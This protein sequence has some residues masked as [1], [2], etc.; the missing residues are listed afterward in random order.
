MLGLS[1]W[2][3]L[4]GRGSNSVANSAELQYKIRSGYGW[5][6]VY[7]FRWG[8]IPLDVISLLQNEINRLYGAASP[9]RGAIP[10]AEIFTGDYYPMRYNQV[11]PIGKWD[12]SMPSWV[13]DDIWVG[14][15]FYRP[16]LQM[17]LVQGFR[18]STKAPTQFVFYPQGLTATQGYLVTNLDTKAKQQISGNALM[19]QGIT[20]SCPSAATS[21]CTGL[22][23]IQAHKRRPLWS[24]RRHAD[25]PWAILGKMG[26]ARLG[27]G[28]S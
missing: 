20:M 8:H 21:F 23:T 4:Q 13:N 1:L 24:P 6:G 17:G 16:D 10:L 14:W 22:F 26:N 7:A 15:Q 19:N 12:G 25:K 28:L 18:R 2:L 5:T 27:S 11:P 3:P 9:L